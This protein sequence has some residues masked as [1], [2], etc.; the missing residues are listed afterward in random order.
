MGYAGL[1]SG[2]VLLVGLLSPFR[3]MAQDH[4]P[5]FAD[6]EARRLVAGALLRGPEPGDEPVTGVVRSRLRAGFLLPDQWSW[7]Y[8]TLFRKQT[9]GVAGFPAHDESGRVLARA[10]GAPAIGDQ[11]IDRRPLGAIGFDP[12]R[13]RPPLL[14]FL[15]LSFGTLAPDLPVGGVLGVYDVF[16]SVFV[17]PLSA[18]GP[19]TYRY[20]TGRDLVL[21]GSGVAVLK[22]VEF[23]TM[24][25]SGR[26][27]VGIIWFDAVSGAPI[28]SMIRP[29]GKWELEGGLRGAARRIPVV[30]GNALGSIDYLTVT[31]ERRDGR[32]RP[33]EAHLHGA[34]SMLWDQVT[35]PVQVDWAMDFDV[36]PPEA[37]EAWL[38]EPLRGGWSASLEHDRLNPFVRALDRLAGPPPASTVTQTLLLTAVGVRFNQVQGVSIP[39]EYAAPLGARTTTYAG[40]R[41]ATSGFQ[42][43]GTVRVELDSYPRRYRVEGYSRLRDANWMEPANGLGRSL[44]ALL[45]GI[46]AGSYYLASGGSVRVEAGDRPLQG[47]MSFFAEDHRAVAKTA[48]YSLFEPDTTRL[49]ADLPVDDGAYY[50]LRTSAHLQLGDDAQKGVLVAR[51]HGQAAT[52]ARS[53]V[54][55]GTAT[56]LVGPLPGPFTGGVRVQ[57]AV[58]ND[59]APRQAHYYLGGYKTIRGYPVDAASGPAALILTGE[60]G[61]DVPLVRLVVFGEVGWA[62]R[63]DRL[64]VD[65]GLATVGGGLSIADGILRVDIARG[66]SAG[67]EWRFFIATSGLL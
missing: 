63:L 41:I 3:A 31:Y 37:P 1:T 23:R 34:V 62:D 32:V 66:I 11:L 38:P 40:V 19:A 7:R 48:T 15:G 17:D 20:A 5:A 36:M 39:V 16:D 49:P 13:E 22:S 52:G 61:T 47:S 67:G 42:P 33:A 27:V 43:T 44:T 64:L 50:G 14:G 59:R 51:V 25:Q 28:R 35:L 24:E 21:R 6:A 4:G 12:E 54:A 45:S 56:D 60:I 9:V 65:R 26:E 58:A 57:A 55:V 53:F 8:R 2:L 10:R 46:D 30:P 29:E 18:R